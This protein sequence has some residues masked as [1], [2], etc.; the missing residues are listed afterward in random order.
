MFYEHPGLPRETEWHLSATANSH[1]P[2]ARTARKVRGM[3]AEPFGV[4]P[5][6][7]AR[8]PSRDASAVIAVGQ[9]GS[10]S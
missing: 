5:T 3:R 2:Y 4:Y 1:E 9:A 10:F 8:S 6:L 7:K